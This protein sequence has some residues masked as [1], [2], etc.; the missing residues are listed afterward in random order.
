MNDRTVPIGAFVVGCASTETVKEAKG[1]GVTRTYGYAYQPVCDATL[2]AAKTKAL[3]GH[4]AA[5]GAA[6]D[7]EPGVF[8]LSDPR[9]M[10]E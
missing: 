4:V 9:R 7:L 5:D 1:Q 2:A 3:E 10:R 8:A 6:L